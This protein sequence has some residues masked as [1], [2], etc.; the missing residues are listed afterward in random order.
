M[1]DPAAIAGPGPEPPAAENAAAGRSD[2][3][4]ILREL[5]CDQHRFFVEWYNGREPGH[6]AFE[7]FERGLG[8]GFRLITPDGRTLERG[9]VISFVRANR[10]IEDGGF[11]IEIA[12]VSIRARGADLVVATYT[13]AQI[14]NNKQTTRL[15]SAV[16]RSAPRQ[17][18]GVIWEHL[19]ETWVDRKKTEQENTKSRGIR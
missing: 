9:D 2:D 7:S 6:G 10:G 15:S 3:L 11:D 14:R 18:S 19:H 13:E 12:D 1:V 8:A 17:V 16:F 4:S 5:I